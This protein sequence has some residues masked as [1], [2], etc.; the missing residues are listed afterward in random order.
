MKNTIYSLLFIFLATSLTAQT[1]KNYKTF[2]KT[3]KKEQSVFGIS[4]PFSVANWFIDSEE[5]ELKQIIKRGNKVR[6]L[7]FSDNNSSVYRDINHYLPANVYEKYL[8]IK[9]KDS[10]IKL[11]VREQKDRISEIIVLIKDNNSFVT[12][13]IYGDF[14]YDDLN[15]LSKN[16]Q[17]DKG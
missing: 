13:G 9:N 15:E 2:Y 1:E 16:I 17:Q 7:V 6:L 4:A 8:S 3:F 14:T 12:M 10:K 5:K 11:L